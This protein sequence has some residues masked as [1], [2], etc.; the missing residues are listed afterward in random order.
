MPS[1]I[2]HPSAKI[3][4]TLH[5]GPRREDGFH[6]IRSV[7]QSIAL[8][9]RLK[10]TPKR[11]PFSLAVRS[12]AVPADRTN[13]V[14]R[15]A[16]V[17]WRAAGRAGEPNGVAIA[18]EKSIPVAAGLGG[19]SAD[20][21]A[22]LAGLNAI[23]R[24]RLP[25][26]ELLRL[27]AA[28]GS[29]VPFF[30][31]GGTALALG[32]GGEIYP[33]ADVKRLAVVLI[34]PAFGVSTAEAYR[35]FDE[36]AGRQPSSDSAE[37]DVAWPGGPLALVNDLQP[38][39]ARRHPEVAEMIVGLVRAGA[40]AAAM[41]GSGSCV[42]GVLPQAKV[43]PRTVRRLHRPGWNVMVARTLSRREALQRIGLC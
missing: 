14:W 4:L 26:R 8:S 1:L 18:L 16:E 39:V 42:F 41:S 3:N 40:S 15:A 29:D 24:T 9:D 25:R 7:M 13:L 38:P 43:N 2:L 19:G 5:V 30:L 33:L 37:L 10:L 31:T 6:E 23:W 20:A 17:L 36:D 32:R 11:G 28:V 22:A 27:A 34:K 35:W 21:A 12:E